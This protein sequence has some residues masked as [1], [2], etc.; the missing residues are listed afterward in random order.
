PEEET[1]ETPELDWVIPPN[2]YLRLR[3]IRLMPWPKRIKIQKKTSYFEKLEIWPPSSNGIA[4]RLE[5][6]SSSKL[7]LKVKLTR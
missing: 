4:N 1:P 7:T 2:A 6:R 5:R 3:T